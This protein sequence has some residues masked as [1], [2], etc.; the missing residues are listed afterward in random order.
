MSLIP[1]N[2]SVSVYLDCILFPLTFTELLD[3]IE[4][5]G[6]LL[7]PSL[8]VVRPLGRFR[9][10]GQIGTKGKN[11]FQVDAGDKALSIFG[12]SLE[13]VQTEF[14]AFCK[15]LLEDYSI[16]IDE[17]IKF[18]QYAGNYE[19]KT[20]LN[21]YDVISRSY[22]SP[23]HE[24]VSEIFGESIKTF[25]IRLAISETLPKDVDWF[26]V[27]ITPDIQ[28]NNGYIIEVAYRK[29]DKEKYQTFTDNFESNIIKI[30]KHLEA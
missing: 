12:V 22:E 2:I 13:E 21:P 11:I 17:M 10:S 27:K 19:Y 26:D 9:G 16:D 1:V 23:H 4:K 15:T 25:A 7:N 8:P 28:R 18:Y 29:K 3:S 24:K 20:K 6:Y 14:D 30:I 5:N